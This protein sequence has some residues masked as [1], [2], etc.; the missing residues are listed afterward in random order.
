MNAMQKIMAGVRDLGLPFTADVPTVGDGNCFFRAV[1]QQLKFE[2][3]SPFKDH[4]ELRLKLVDFVAHNV[5]LRGVEEFCVARDLYIDTR[6][7]EGETRNACWA[8]LLTNMSRSGVWA[9]DVFVECTALFL[10]RKLQ[11][12]SSEHNMQNPWTIFNGENGV[13]Q[14]QLRPLTLGMLPN[15]HFQSLLPGEVANNPGAVICRKCGF[16]TPHSILRHLSRRNDCMQFYDMTKLKAEAV[17]KIKRNRNDSRRQKRKNESFEK[18][19]SISAAKKIRLDL[20]GDRLERFKASI[21]FGPIFAC[22]VCERNMFMDSV[23]VIGANECKEMW[24]SCCNEL[25]HEIEK[26]FNE[27]LVWHV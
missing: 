6:L 17:E 12:T 1:Q 25:G 10:K 9:E 20:H 27:N 3:D 19:N 5:E 14:T 2:G 24:E 13:G 4:E 22:F 8:R 23:K 21:K 7:S 16:I 26:E 15:V 18:R 11:I